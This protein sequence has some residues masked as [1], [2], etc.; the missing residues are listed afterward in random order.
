MGRRK[1]FNVF[2]DGKVHVVR[3][4]CKTCIYRPGFKGI[5]DRAIAAARAEDN[6]VVCHS[7]LDTDANAV[8]GGFYSAE[9]T[10]PVVLAKATG[11]VQF[12]KPCKR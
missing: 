6:V 8:C 12:V 10:T 3:P 4:A 11:M 2:R 7:T 1:P 5:G 9:A